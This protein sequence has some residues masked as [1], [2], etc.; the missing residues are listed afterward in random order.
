MEPV[1][2]HPKVVERRN[3][4][5]KFIRD[6]AAKIIIEQLERL[7]KKIPIMGLNNLSKPK[8]YGYGLILHPRPTLPNRMS[9]LFWHTVYLP[10]QMVA[11]GI[12]SDNFEVD[13][14]KS[15]MKDC[16]CLLTNLHN[17]LDDVTV[18]DKEIINRWKE[19]IWRK[20][21]YLL[22]TANAFG[23]VQDVTVY[24][25]KKKVDP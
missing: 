4:P 21:R 14:A 3:N 13:R 2:I 16:L 17:N 7:K 15:L 5:T 22:N 23:M 9:K 18:V 20:K 12:S 11:I 6:D 24:S 8:D 19:E 1:L 10:P 25:G